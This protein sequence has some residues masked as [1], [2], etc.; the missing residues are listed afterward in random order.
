MRALAILLASLI[1]TPA[2]AQMG[3][4]DPQAGRALATTWCSGCHVIDAQTSKAGDAV[5]SFPTI[6]KMPSTTELSLQAFLQTPHER[7]PNFQ[8]SR[9]QVDDAVAYILSLKR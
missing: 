5:P 7:M 2:L 9:Q 3:P 8:L 1:T 4:G 6:A